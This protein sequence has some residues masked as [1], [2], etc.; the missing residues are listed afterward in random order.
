M[1][2]SAEVPERSDSDRRDRR[3]V[4]G[5]QQCPR[6][7]EWFTLSYWNADFLI[8]A[9]CFSCDLRWPRPDVV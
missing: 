9:R 5:D 3:V 4:V 7:H 8:Q 1:S 6:C 2:E